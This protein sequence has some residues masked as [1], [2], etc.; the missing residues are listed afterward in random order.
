MRGIGGVGAGELVDAFQAVGQGPHAQ[1]ETAGG[2]GG[3]AAGVEVRGEGVEEGPGA[4]PGVG[5]WAERVRHKVGHGLA[6]AGEDGLD[7]Q[8]GGAQ[9]GVV[10]VESLGHL[11]GAEGLLVGLDDSAG[12]RCGRPIATRPPSVA[13]CACLAK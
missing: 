10:E 5:E 12:A 4:D 2:F 1:G 13:A 11:Q 3:A 6:V 9:H 7:E 8:V